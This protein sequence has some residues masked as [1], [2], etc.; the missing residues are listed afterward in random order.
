MTLQELLDL[1]NKELKEHPESKNRKI[2]FYTPTNEGGGGSYII[3]KYHVDVFTSLDDN[4]VSF[5]IED[6][7]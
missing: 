2:I 7:Y 1:L 4:T 3:N 5:D 6:V